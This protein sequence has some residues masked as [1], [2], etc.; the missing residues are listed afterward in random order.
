MLILGESLINDGAA[1]SSITRMPVL[2]RV[3]L[4]QRT[5]HSHSSVTRMTVLM[6]VL[7]ARRTYHSP[8]SLRMVV[9]CEHLTSRRLRHRRLDKRPTLIEND[10]H[11]HVS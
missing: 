4:V 5:E 9:Q 10:Y 3:L 7:P 11:S 2:M 1:H 6:R 8:S